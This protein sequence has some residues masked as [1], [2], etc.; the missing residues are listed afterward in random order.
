MTNTNEIF[1]VITK[2]KFNCG[3]TSPGQD[4]GANCP[5]WTYVCNYRLPEDRQPEFVGR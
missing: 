5:K 2:A 1:K 3:Q 4:K